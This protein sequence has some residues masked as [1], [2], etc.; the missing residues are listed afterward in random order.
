MRILPGAV[1]R[2]I[3][4][5]QDGLMWLDQNM[6]GRGLIVPDRFTIVD[7]ILYCALDFGCRVGQAFDR[8][9]TSITIWYEQ[10]AKRPSAMA[11]LYP[12]AK[13]AGMRF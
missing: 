9:L 12:T 11:S 6:I 3:A 4:L 2:L 5:S 1:P 10:I 13:S 7:I 8:N